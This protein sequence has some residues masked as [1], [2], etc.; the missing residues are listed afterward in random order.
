MEYINAARYED[1]MNLLYLY[2]Q[3]NTTVLKNVHQSNIEVDKFTPIIDNDKNQ[4]I[5][6]KYYVNTYHK[7]SINH[8]INSVFSF[9][10]TRNMIEMMFGAYYKIWKW[11]QD[12]LLWLIFYIINKPKNYNYV[13]KIRTGEAMYV[14]LNS[15]ACSVTVLQMKQNKVFFFTVGVTVTLNH[16]KIL[17]T[18]H[19][20]FYSKFISPATIKSM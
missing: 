16:I 5:Y 14:K 7:L 17:S 1:L 18:E 12:A 11:F 10:H 13:L 19:Q 2:H 6:S 20:C 8:K 3:F 9:Y 15:V 4:L